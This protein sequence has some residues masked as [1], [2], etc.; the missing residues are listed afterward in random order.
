MVLC[1]HN[2]LITSIA[3]ACLNKVESQQLNAVLIQDKIGIR[4]QVYCQKKS[5]SCDDLPMIL[6]TPCINMINHRETKGV[7]HMS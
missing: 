2:I 5:L 3:P 7:F 1:F 4:Y 6:L